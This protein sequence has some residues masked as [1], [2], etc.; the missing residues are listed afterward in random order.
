MPDRIALRGLTVRGNHGVFDFE[1]RDGQDFVI[2]VTLHASTAAAAATDDIA[3]TIH[4]GELAEDV[5]RIVED[6]TFD[7][8]ET[9][10]EAIAAHCL[11]LTERVEVVVHKPSAPIERTFADVTVTVDRSRETAA[12]ADGSDPASASA[13]LSLGA[14]LGEAATTLDEAV[15]ALDRHPRISVAS[16]SSLYRTAPWGGVEQ[17]DFLNLG[18]IVETT[19]PPRELLAVCQGIEVACGRTRELRWGPR[20]LD[21]DVIAYTVRGVDVVLDSAALTLPHPRAHERAFVL[22]PWAEIAPDTVVDSPTGPRPIAEAIA[23]LDDQG[24]ERADA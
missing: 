19:L 7:L 23:S 18:V 14:N 5:A 21:I 13:Y 24:I 1:K 20:T 4:Y 12:R 15:A 6:N 10:A 2:D 3:D 8:I 22:V 9:L 11:T 16:R 17:N